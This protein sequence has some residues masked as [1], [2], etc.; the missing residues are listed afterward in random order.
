MNK[1]SRNKS[2]S[3][4][5][6]YVKDSVRIRASHFLAERLMVLD[7]MI[8]PQNFKTLLILD[9][10]IFD[11]QTSLL[12]T[13]LGELAISDGQRQVRGKVGYS[14][15]QPWIFSGTVKENIVFGQ[16]F[17]RVRYQQVIKACALEKVCLLL[18]NYQVRH[19]HIFQNVPCLPPKSCASFVFNS[20]RDGCNTEEKW[21]TKVIQNFGC[22]TRCVMGDVQ[23][24]SN[25]HHGENEAGSSL[26]Y[27]FSSTVTSTNCHSSYF[28]FYCVLL[29]S[30]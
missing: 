9:R 24:A 20:F 28:L 19:L 7:K 1:N 17:N 14:S 2:A 11:L 6:K 25:V 3:A 29:C 30:I 4:L 15:Q 23:M 13:I 27:S 12:M 16:E 10:F 22:Q 18:K 21:K 8:W 5:N 26:R